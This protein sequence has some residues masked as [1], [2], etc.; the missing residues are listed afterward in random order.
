[1]VARA[2]LGAPNVQ[3]A[4]DRL[5]TSRRR[6]SVTPREKRIGTKRVPPVLQNHQFGLAVEDE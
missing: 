5:R 6:R 1:M 2:I 4:G 3:F